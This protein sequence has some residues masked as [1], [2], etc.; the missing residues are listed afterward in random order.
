[1]K[2]TIQNLWLKLGTL[3][4]VGLATA[5]A[6]LA[7]QFDPNDPLGKR[8]VTIPALPVNDPRKIASNIIQIFLGFL[9]II[10]VSIILIG[11]FQWMT[12]LG[13]EEKV[14]K[15]RS[16]I[17]SGVVGLV[18]IIASYAIATFVIDQILLAASQR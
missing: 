6:A 4:T 11:G 1:M 8:F 5:G 7:Q 2:P 3:T 12:A 9:G 16:L 10:A 15:A 13:D 18:I 14:K 17:A